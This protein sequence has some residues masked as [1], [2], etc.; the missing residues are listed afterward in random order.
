MSVTI[1]IF[2]GYPTLIDKYGILLAI[3]SLGSYFALG[4]FIIIYRIVDKV[5]HK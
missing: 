5:K 3:L 2:R 4:L 1:I